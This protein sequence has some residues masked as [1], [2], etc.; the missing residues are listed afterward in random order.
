VISDTAAKRVGLDP[1]KPI[2][3][4][5]TSEAPSSAATD[6]A[7][8]HDSGSSIASSCTPTK[9]AAATPSASSTERYAA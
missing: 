8:N 4:A 7:E 3:S 9:T 6:A 1:G 5:T 2:V